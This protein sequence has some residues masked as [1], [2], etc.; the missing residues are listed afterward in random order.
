MNSSITVVLTETAIALVS[1]NALLTS[2]PLRHWKS[3]GGSTWS[4]RLRPHSEVVWLMDRLRTILRNGRNDS[5]MRLVSRVM[6]EAPPPPPSKKAPTP[7]SSNVAMRPARTI[8][9]AARKFPVA[10]YMMGTK[11]CVP[12]TRRVDA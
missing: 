10:R 2:I 8:R 12:I 11:S 6:S 1:K 9:K 3:D 4:G 7:E 5:V